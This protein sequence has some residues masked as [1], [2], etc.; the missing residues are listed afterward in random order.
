MEFLFASA[1]IYIIRNVKR[2]VYCLTIQLILYL[3]H[4]LPYNK[5]TRYGKL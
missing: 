4:S 5:D 2:I 3:S 1:E